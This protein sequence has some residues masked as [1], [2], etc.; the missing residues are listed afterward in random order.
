MSAPMFSVDWCGKRLLLSAVR[1][2]R[3]KDANMIFVER[4]VRQC[5]RKE[6]AFKPFS[7]SM[8]NEQVFLAGGESGSGYFLSEG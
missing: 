3:R 6:A 1:A 4:G 5:L 2:G 8:E 7:Q